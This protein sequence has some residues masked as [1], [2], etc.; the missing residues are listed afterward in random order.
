LNPLTHECTVEA[1]RLTLFFSSI[2]RRS[3]ILLIPEPDGLLML[4]AGVVLLVCLDYF[5]LA[6]RSSD[7]GH[8]R[9]RARR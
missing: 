3:G 5:R 2:V 6:S 9:L 1:S 4:V 8:P 7:F